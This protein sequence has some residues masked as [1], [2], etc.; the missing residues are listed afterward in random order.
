MTHRTA[1]VSREVG[2]PFLLISEKPAPITSATK[3]R[4]PQTN[5]PLRALLQKNR[6]CDRSRFDPLEAALPG[7]VTARSRST[8][9]WPSNGL[10][11]IGRA[12]S[13]ADGRGGAA[14]DVEEA[15][16]GDGGADGADRHAHDD[17]DR[18]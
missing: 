1:S 7:P 4:I 15:S 12:G 5:E 16:D 3:A 8:P 17:D 6:D 9:A 18:V 13:G 2:A 14:S 11:A 10:H